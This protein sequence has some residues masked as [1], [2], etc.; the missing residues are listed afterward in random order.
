MIALALGL[1]LVGAAS[2]CGT[3]LLRPTGRIAFVLGTAVLAFAEIVAVSHGLSFLDAYERAAGSSSTAAVL[4]LAAVSRRRVSCRP[5]WPSLDVGAAARDVVSDR[6]VAVLGVLVAFE[7]LYLLA[8]AVVHSAGERDALTYHLTRA[9]LWIQQQS[10]RAGR[11]RCRHPD[12]RASSRTPRSSQGFTMLL[13]GSARWVALR[14]ARRC[15]SRRLAIYGI[16]VRFG[17][18]RRRAAAFGALLFP[19]LPVVALQAPTCAERPRRRGA[20]R[21]WRPSLVLGR[22]P[23]ELGL[24]CVAVALLV[25]TKVTG[26]LALP[27]LLSSRPHAPRQASRAGARRRRRRS[28]RGGAWFAVNL[29]EGHG[30]FGAVGEGSKRYG[31]G[32]SADRCPDDALRRRDAR[33]SGRDGEGRTR[34]YVIAAGVVAIVGLALRPAVA[35]LGAA[36]LTLLPLQSRSLERVLHSVY[37]HGWTLIGYYRGRSPSDRGRD[38][39]SASNMAS[40]YGPVGLALTL[41]SIVRRDPAG[42]REDAPAGSRRCWPVTR[43]RTRRYGVRRRLPPP[44]RPLRD[45]R[46]RALAPPHGASSGP[47]ARPPPRPRRRRHDRRSSPS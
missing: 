11:R 19:T 25:G 30:P 42:A 13:S 45:G 23:G 37:W 4:A 20:R 15:S 33:A 7:L 22:S 28:S 24:A 41:L 14:A 40:W 35:V 8:L 46:R 34:I 26:L 29:S 5:S 12:R 9:L 44:R 17:F 18:D 3:A 32:V 36:A 43:P 16:A 38:P 47:S 27:L 1:L 2:S 10:V 39:S 31:G 6:V 21:D